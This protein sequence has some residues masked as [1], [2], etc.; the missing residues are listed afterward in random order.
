MEKIEK[1]KNVSC[2]LA[3]TVAMFINSFAMA[4]LVKSSFGISTLSSLPLVLYDIFPVIS[5]GMMNTLIQVTLLIT[6]MVITRQPK[7][8][9]IFSFII[10]FLFGLLIDLMDFLVLSWPNVLLLRIVYFIAGWVLISLGGAIFIL[11]RLPLMPFDCTVRDLAI[12]LKKPVRKVKTTLDAIF[13]LSAIVL[14]LVFL[15]RLEGAGV[16]TILMAFFTGTLVQYF[17][18]QLSTRFSFQCT[19]KAGEKL[20]EF[21]AVQVKED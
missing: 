8:S 6:V 13:V 20:A 3:W 16:G 14:S 15:K 17:T 5:F 10:S 11:C 2:E 12:Y 9:Y 18:D 7:I 19:T 21:V 1:Q 4:I